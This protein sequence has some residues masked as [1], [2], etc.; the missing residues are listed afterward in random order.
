MYC[1]N[2]TILVDH[3]GLFIFVD[4]GYPRLFHDVMILKN[5][6]VKRNWRTLFSNT[7]EY[8]EYVL[9]DHG[10]IGL[11]NYIIQGLSKVEMR[12]MDLPRGLAKTFKLYACRI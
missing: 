6:M 11:E 5:S 3:H 9:G 8:S 4:A 7:N 12:V 10:Y 2:S 1:M